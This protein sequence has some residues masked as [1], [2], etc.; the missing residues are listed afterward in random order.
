M[1]VV[2]G[3]GICLVFRYSVGLGN[4]LWV[5]TS[6]FECRV[7]RPPTTTTTAQIF[8]RPSGLAY[9]N[10]FIYNVDGSKSCQIATNLA[11]SCLPDLAKSCLP[12]FPHIPSNLAKSGQIL[13]NLDKSRQ[14]LEK[15]AKSCQILPNFAKSR[16]IL[17]NLVKSRSIFP[18]RAICAKISRYVTKSRRILQALAKSRQ[19]S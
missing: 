6:K 11:N 17:P 18:S 7:L 16:Q 14:I 8:P 2:W 3:W 1:D 13:R 12:K 10:G 9:A 19:S 5:S 15:P 4:S